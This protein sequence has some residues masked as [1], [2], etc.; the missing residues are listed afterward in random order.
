MCCLANFSLILASASFSI[1]SHLLQYFLSSA[2][3]CSSLFVLSTLVGSGFLFGINL[4][5]CVRKNIFFKPISMSHLRFYVLSLIIP[6]FSLSHIDSIVYILSRQIYSIYIFQKLIIHS[7]TS[8]LYF[9]KCL[10]YFY[11]FTYVSFKVT[12]TSYSIFTGAVLTSC[13]FRTFGIIFTCGTCSRLQR[14]A[15]YDV[16]LT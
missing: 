14:V 6:I 1:F 7:Y 8:L 9:I 12:L 13:D 4:R 11:F 5:V 10:I 2:I 16:T 3:S 15:T